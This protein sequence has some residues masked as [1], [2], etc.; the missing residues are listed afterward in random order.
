M[1]YITIIDRGKTLVIAQHVSSQLY[2]KYVLTLKH[3]FTNFQLISLFH[4]SSYSCVSVRKS[5]GYSKT[6]HFASSGR[7]LTVSGLL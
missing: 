2:K 6:C 1:V 4:A 3:R 7:L 5:A